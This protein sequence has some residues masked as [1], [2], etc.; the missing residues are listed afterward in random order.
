MTRVWRR[1]LS[2]DDAT[3]SSVWVISITDSVVPLLA[4][5]L[6]ECHRPSPGAVGCPLLMDTF[7]GS[8]QHFSFPWCCFYVLCQLLGNTRK[9]SVFLY[10]PTPCP[11]LLPTVGYLSR[12]KRAKPL[13]SHSLYICIILSPT[14]IAWTHQQTLAWNASPASSNASTSW[15]IEFEQSTQHPWLPEYSWIL[16]LLLG[17]LPPTP[18]YQRTEWLID[19]SFLVL[20]PNPMTVS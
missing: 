6:V 14:L 15:I 16:L 11:F 19:I 7:Q 2:N 18:P 5:G 20:S 12:C 10:Y 17:V 3:C 9:N 8:G 1:T 4:D 13:P